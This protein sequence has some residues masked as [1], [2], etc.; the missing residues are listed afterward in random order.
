MQPNKILIGESVAFDNKHNGI[1]SA[2]DN[3]DIRWYGKTNPKSV[4][5]LSTSMT[6]LEV[7]F[8]QEWIKQ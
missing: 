2:K 8:P 5:K 6:I 7:L 3:R 1:Q 4:R